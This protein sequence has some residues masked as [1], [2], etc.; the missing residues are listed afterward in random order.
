MDGYTPASSPTTEMRAAQPPRRGTL[1]LMS[2]AVVVGLILGSVVTGAALYK[3]GVRCTVSARQAG[4]SVLTDG[5]DSGTRTSEGDVELRL[6]PGRHTVA[7]RGGGGAMLG[8]QQ[9]EVASG[10][11][12]E[13]RF[14]RAG[15]EASG[16]TR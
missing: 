4:L 14:P 13:M 5:R 16:S 3:H 8:E 2:M 11:S 15:D 12:C 9:V 1:E 6:P 10:Q 7:L